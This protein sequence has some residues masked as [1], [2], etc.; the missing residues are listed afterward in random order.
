MRERER[1]GKK[2]KDTSISAKASLPQWMMIGQKKKPNKWEEEEEN[3]GH[4]SQM[5]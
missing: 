1:E 3:E 5:I 2:D 4:A